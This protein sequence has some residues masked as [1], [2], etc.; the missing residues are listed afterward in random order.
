MIGAL[1][2]IVV[3][4]LAHELGQLLA[5]RVLRVPARF[6]ARFPSLVEITATRGK[7]APVIAVGFAAAYL[8][9]SAIA[10]AELAL[11]GI[12]T[13]VGV[14][15]GTVLPGYGAEG[16]LIAGDRIATLDGER[17]DIDEGPTFAER[18][19]RR[20]GAPVV[21]GVVRDGVP[22]EISVTPKPDPRGW[23]LGIRLSRVYETR[24]DLL[25][26]ARIA[27][28]YPI[29]QSIELGRH[30]IDRI[31]GSGS[32]PGGPVRIVEEVRIEPSLLRFA[33][34]D[35]TYILLLLAAVDLVRLLRR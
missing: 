7:R 1:L 34:L 8:A 31:V 28:W 13:R 17:L 2:A 33:M 22:L 10:F 24:S 32:E 21:L 18:V 3:L 19:N 6:R 30:M 11:N 12:P 35:G 23:V 20:G 14:A 25:D 26:S 16:K 9:L 27:L 5:G 4:G 29:A 15:V